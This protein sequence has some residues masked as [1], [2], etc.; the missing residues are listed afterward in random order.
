MLTTVLALRGA[1]LLT[2]API[3]AVLAGPLTTALGPRHVLVDT[4]IAM[5]VLAGCSTVVTVTK[6]RAAATSS[7]KSERL[8][9]R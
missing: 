5:I 4:G 7:Y 1:V 8:R 2:A 6:G 3:G 9:V